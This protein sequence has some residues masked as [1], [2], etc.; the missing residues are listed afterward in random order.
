MLELLLLIKIYLYVRI[1]I[2]RK[3][4]LMDMAIED[5]RFIGTI[6][7]LRLRAL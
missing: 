3:L 5:G 6:T 7:Q 4:K 1:F 2:Y